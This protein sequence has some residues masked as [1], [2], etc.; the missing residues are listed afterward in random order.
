MTLCSVQQEVQQPSSEQD[1]TKCDAVNEEPTGPVLLQSVHAA[2]STVI[3]SQSD[4]IP[5]TTN[6][7]QIHQGMEALSVTISPKSKESILKI[8]ANLIGRR[9]GT[10]SVAALF[11]SDSARAV[12]ATSNNGPVGWFVPIPL[13]YRMNQEWTLRLIYRFAFPILH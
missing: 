12:Y 3:Y 11:R 10:I 9:E 4:V 8:R 2:T 5:W 7:P 6:T 13:D 1:D